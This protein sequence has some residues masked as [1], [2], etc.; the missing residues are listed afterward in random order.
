[1]MKRRATWAS[2]VTSGACGKAV[3]H[4]DHLVSK[5]RFFPLTNDLSRTLAVK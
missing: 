2:R 3:L 4:E 1:M 5:F